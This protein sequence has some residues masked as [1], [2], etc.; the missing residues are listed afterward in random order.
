[1]PTWGKDGGGW[2]GGPWTQWVTFPDGYTAVL[3]SNS[4]A[5][6]IPFRQMLEQTYDAA[7]Q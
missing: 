3:F 5:G 1:M 7:W 6:A 4:P 2:A